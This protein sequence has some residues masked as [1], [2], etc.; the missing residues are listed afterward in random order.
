MLH[1]ILWQAGTMKAGPF[2][3]HLGDHLFC[4][5]VKI[6]LHLGYLGP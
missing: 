2:R 5:S 3:R 1:V 4:H 6:A